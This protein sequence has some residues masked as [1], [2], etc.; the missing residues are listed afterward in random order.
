MDFYF[1]SIGHSKSTIW[2]C[3][4]LIWCHKL[5]NEW[6]LQGHSWRLSCVLSSYKSI[7]TNL[8]D[9]KSF[10]KGW[11]TSK[12]KPKHFSQLYNNFIQGTIGAFSK[13]LLYRATRKWKSWPCFSFSTFNNRH[14]CSR[15]AKLVTVK[16]TKF[17]VW[18]WQ[19]VCNGYV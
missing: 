15:F 8:Y 16:A 17:G 12:W 4:K 13:K 7:T 6:K 19:K 10:G 3:N 1:T 11:I 5:S 18:V 9:I 14:C 2:S